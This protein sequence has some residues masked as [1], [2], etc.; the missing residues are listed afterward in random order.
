[1]VLATGF[2]ATGFFAV[3][4]V[5]ATLVATFSTSANASAATSLAASRAS[6]ATVKAELEAALPVRVKR[7]LIE[8]SRLMWVSVFDLGWTIESLEVFG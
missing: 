6:C 7:F 1:M 8:S 4:A 2:F 5:F 3:A